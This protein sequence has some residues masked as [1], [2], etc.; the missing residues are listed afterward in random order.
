MTATSSLEALG[1]QNL[2]LACQLFYLLALLT[3]ADR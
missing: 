2:V 3:Y 1:P